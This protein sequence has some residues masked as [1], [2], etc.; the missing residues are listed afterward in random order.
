MHQLAELAYEGGTPFG[1]T[2]Y[3]DASARELPMLL[4]SSNRGCNFLRLDH[5]PSLGNR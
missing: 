4:T 5:F 2:T 1:R 3:P